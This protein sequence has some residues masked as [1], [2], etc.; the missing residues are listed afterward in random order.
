MDVSSLEG[1]PFAIWLAV[2]LASGLCWLDSW[3]K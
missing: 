3:R 2:L 1:R